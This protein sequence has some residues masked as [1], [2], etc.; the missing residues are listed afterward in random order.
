MVR[1]LGVSVDVIEGDEH[2]NLRGAVG[3][4]TAPFGGAYLV[5]Q[6]R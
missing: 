4:I 6:G 1:H 2:R 3:A 5:W